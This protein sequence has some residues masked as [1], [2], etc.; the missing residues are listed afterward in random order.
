M[1]KNKSFEEQ[2]F[3]CIDCE[4]TGLDPKNDYIIEIAAVSFNLAGNIA[5][6]ESLVNPGC[7][8]P[9]SSIEIHRITN[10]M[11][12]DKPSI[13][14]VLPSVL[15]V[16]GP[17][18]I[19]GHGVNFDIEIVAQSAQKNRIPTKIRDNLFLDTLRMAR[20]YGDCPVN[21]L[22]QLRK[23]FNVPHE[24]A[25]RAMN[26]VIVNIGVFKQLLKQYKNLSQLFEA[27]SRPIELKT[28]PLGKYKGRAIK[29]L[30]SDYLHWSVKKDFDQDLLYTLRAEINRRKKG[31]L[32]SQ[33]SNPF[34]ELK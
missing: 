23:H 34:N 28:M 31:G 3:V 15:E 10:E 26:D 11:V 17:N 30:P 16:I 13:E 19:V 32:F 9:Q 24:E 1:M 22:K 5:T 2:V 4:T 7:E 33:V 6:F 27:L 12:A 14:K 8:I 29:E 25:H 20:L 21:S 18:I